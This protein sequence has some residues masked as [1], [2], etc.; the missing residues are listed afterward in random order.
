[1]NQAKRLN[2]WN[3]LPVAVPRLMASSNPR[4]GEIKI[5]GIVD[6]SLMR[7]LDDSGFIDR[8]YNVYPAK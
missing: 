7:K 4:I 5:E 6:R 8:I 1:L 2:D 3:H